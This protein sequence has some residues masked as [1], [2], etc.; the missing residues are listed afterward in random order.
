MTRIIL[1][2]DMDSFY[3]SVEQRENPALKGLP[4]IVGSD[5][6]DG[7]AR[8]VVSTCSYEA[9]AF[10]IH[11]AMPI[12]RAYKLCPDAAFVR[13]NMPLYAQVSSNIMQ[14]LRSYTDRFQ[15][16]SVD[17]AFLDI[18]N[19]VVDIEGAEVL[20]HE[21]KAHILA[22]EGLT[23]SIGIAPNKS[24]AKIASD[25][26]KPDGLTVVAPEEVED[27]LEPLKVRRLS[28]IGRKNEEILHK[29]GIKTIGQL[30]S[31]DEEILIDA[32]GRWGKNM[33]M[34]ALGLDESEVQERDVV[35][36]VSKEDTFMEDVADPDILNGSLDMIAEKVHRALVRKGFLFKTLSVKVRQEDFTTFSRAK[37]LDTH[38]RDLETI[39]RISRNLAVEF[40]DGKKIRL[41]GIRLSHL[42]KSNIIQT[43]LDDYYMI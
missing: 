42:S 41:L 11:S 17:E 33:R 37:T 39:K 9:R 34:L 12:S 24:I 29:M 20:A 10:G 6:K 36:S 31:F 3:A 22:Q 14:I 15:Q 28:G 26:K 19:M 43:T 32:F 1:H 16:V 2:V 18:S 13:V 35:K 5:P 25:F 23:C 38:T 27:F 4:V 7:H 30:A 21:I 40:F 8:G